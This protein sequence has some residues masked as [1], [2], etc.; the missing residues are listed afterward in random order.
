MNRLNSILDGVDFY[1]IVYQIRSRTV[2]IKS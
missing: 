2:C 1:Y